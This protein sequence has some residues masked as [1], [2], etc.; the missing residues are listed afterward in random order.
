MTKSV[1]T[2]V[3]DFLD[4]LIY[5]AATKLS[6][7]DVNKLVVLAERLPLL[8]EI[9]EKLDERTIRGL[10]RLV[11][12]ASVLGEKYGDCLESAAREKVEPIEGLR[13]IMSI[14]KDEEAMKGLAIALSFIKALGKCG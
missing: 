1:E 2:D 7:E 11:N 12:I 13:G 14:L 3:Y 9:L 5:L 8:L 6:D 4:S 10:E